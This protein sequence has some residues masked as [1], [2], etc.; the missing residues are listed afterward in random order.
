MGD[1]CLAK[2]GK[3]MRVFAECCLLLHVRSFQTQK[4]NNKT[5]APKKKEQRKH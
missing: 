4:Q 5:E 2:V 3:G 1:L